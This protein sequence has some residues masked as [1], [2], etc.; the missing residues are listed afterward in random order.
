MNAGVFA[1]LSLLLAASPPQEFS[2]IGRRAEEARAANRLPE[3]IRLYSQ[4][5][6][7][8]PSWSEGWW[9]LGTVYYDEDRFEEARA[10]LAR[11]TEVSS[12]PVAALGLLALCEYETH[13]YDRALR[14]FQQ[15][16]ARRPPASKE[17]LAVAYFHW[18]L[19]LIR[20]G[21]FER[22]TVLLNARAKL[23]SRDPELEEALGLAALRIA[24]L[25]EDYPPAERELVYLAGKAAMQLAL[26]NAPRAETDARKL[27]AHYDGH[28]NVH[29][30]LGTILLDAHSEPPERE[31]ERELQISPRHVPAMVQLASCR[32]K[33]ARPEEAL[34]LARGALALDARNAPAHKAAGDALL[35]LHRYAESA[36]EL[37]TARGLAPENAP[38][39]FALA[40]VY[41]AL[42]RPTDAQRER[43]AFLALSKNGEDV[44]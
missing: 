30:F 28:P 21:Q 41:K 6:H 8:R 19:L 16:A 37:E 12:D 20:A 10:A 15:W 7:L 22:A 13:D 35:A 38:V 36:T 11:F 43:E 31:F 33:N 23:G 1:A 34:S 42:G 18:A 3:A 27:L 14:H 25:P 2:A 40:R 44:K 24:G 9:G 5:V 39:R 29:Y 17:L 4:G 26:D 32:L